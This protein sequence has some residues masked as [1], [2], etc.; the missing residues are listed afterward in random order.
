MHPMRKIII[1]ILTF[2]YFSVSAQETICDYKNE[3]LRIKQQLVNYFQK[4][5]YH[6]NNSINQRLLLLVLNDRYSLNLA[7]PPHFLDLK[8]SY[9]EDSLVQKYYFRLVNKKYKFN[10]KELKADYV[11]IIGIEH[12]LLWGI[13]SDFL[14]FDEECKKTIHQPLGEDSYSIRAI[15][16][17][18]LAYDWAKR[19]NIGNEELQFFKNQFFKWKVNTQKGLTFLKGFTDTGM[20]GILAFIFMQ[21]IHAIPLDKIKEFLYYHS[22]DGGYPWNEEDLDSNFHASLIAL[23]LTCEILKY[24]H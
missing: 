10:P 15:C 8:V 23:W 12:L 18:L 16:H 4:F 19:N 7:I 9:T 2:I 13:Y 3:F 20:E 21:E 11:K 14:P 6:F 5:D 24:C 17:I 22:S 1:N